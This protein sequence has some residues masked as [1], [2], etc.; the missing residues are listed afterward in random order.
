MATIEDGNVEVIEKRLSPLE[1]QN[2]ESNSLRI[3]M[4]VS[5]ACE[6]GNYIS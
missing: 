2:C 3:G 4:K 1:F 5:K 6:V